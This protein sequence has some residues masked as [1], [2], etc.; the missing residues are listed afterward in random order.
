M[1]LCSRAIVLAVVDKINTAMRVR[2]VGHHDNRD[3]DS[4]TV[5]FMQVSVMEVLS[6]LL[7]RLSVQP[8]KAP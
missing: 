4:D 8:G 7:E 5:H 6:F 2:D 3:I 1:Q